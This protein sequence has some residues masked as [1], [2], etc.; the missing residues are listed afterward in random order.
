[1]IEFTM[2]RIM[3]RFG[4]NLVLNN[5][6][7]TIY[8]KERVALVGKNGS[9]KSTILKLLVGIEPLDR[10]DREDTRDNRDRGWVKI[11]K[12]VTVGYLNQLPNYPG[13]IKVVD[14]LKLAFEEVYTIEK[15]LRALESN[16]TQLEG[17]ALEKVLKQYSKLQEVYEAKG[18]YDIDEKLSEI[19][20][21]L[22]FD[23]A[24]LNKDF[25]I[26]SGGEKTTVSLGKIL[27]EGPDILLL[28]E[29]TNHLDMDSIEWLE[30]YLRSYNGIVMV[31]SHDR[32]FL[33]N[34]VTKVIEI[35]DKQNKHYKGNYSEYIKQKEE[36]MLEQF[37]D[38]K[39]QQSKIKAMESAV[40]R[41]RSW[42]HYTRAMSIQKK[43]D[44][45][46]RIDKPRFEKQNIKF[47]FKN[48][49]RS[50]FNVIKG[51]EI[52]KSFNDKTILNK[53]DLN[54][55]YDERVALIGPNGS[56]KTTFLKMLLGEMD[57]DSGILELGANI[58]YAY[59][60]QE[61]TFNNEEDMLIDCFRE[62]KSILEGKAREYLSKFMF[63]GK[64]VYQN[65]KHLSG[66]EKVRLK[67]SMLL[68]DEIN[69]LILDEPTNHLDID[70]IETLEAALE[71]FKGT[72]FFISHDRYFIN[73]VC[74]RVIALEDNKLVSYGGNYDF[75]KSSKIELVPTS[76]PEKTT[77]AK[78][79][80]LNKAINNDSKK[81]KAELEKLDINI[82]SLE[83][84]LIEIEKL[85]EDSAS[86]YDELNSLYN[87]KQELTMQLEEILEAWLNLENDN[88][89]N[90]L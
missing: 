77:L 51:K 76:A 14:I 25:N 81:R 43:L 3:K 49:D 57:A 53:A 65:V 13:N 26:L 27:L 61:I 17:D 85:M 6:T 10:D 19:C 73:K 22:K 18:G 52:C 63:F 38:Y 56:G 58:K 79:K 35:E 40:K 75:Y 32:Y 30:G 64:T 31:V 37:K 4:D 90:A 41:L 80:P 21:G 9:G 47:D 66:G 70:S 24:F 1:M 20:K 36:Y 45:M 68:Y 88:K 69:L 74:D 72:I 11:P 48:T 55:S 87:K 82:K 44:K 83:K 71:D 16:M 62:D 78:E 29:P 2:Y 67:L 8:D 15:E 12:G 50:G 7:F 89:V 39:E 5:I 23:D 84:E 86:N 60:P 42:E 33:D 28:D 46:N 54:I 34:V 59:L